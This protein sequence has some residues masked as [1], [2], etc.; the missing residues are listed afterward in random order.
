MILIECFVY[1]IRMAS[2]LQEINANERDKDIR[3][4]ERIFIM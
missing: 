2:L 3:F 4:Q 1:N